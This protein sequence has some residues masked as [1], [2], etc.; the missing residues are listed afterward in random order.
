V[1]TSLTESFSFTVDLALIGGMMLA[2]PFVTYQVWRFVAPGLYSR[3]KRLV[4]PLVLMAV[5]G[6]L[7]G[8]AFGHYLLFP[9]SVE[10]L[11]HWLPPGVKLMAGLSDTFGLYK[12]M[13]LAMI[14][15]FQL[16]TVVLLL[17]RLGAV[18]A[19]LL[20]RN[21]RY[22]ILIIV[23]VA[24]AITQTV[25]AW[26]LFFTSGPMLLMY[27]VSIGVAWL[28]RPRGA[29]A[30]PDRGSSAL[31]LLVGAAI[32]EARRRRRLGMRPLASQ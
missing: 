22:A 32:L 15:V 24:A 11:S 5:A 13:M 31:G 7:A 9:T 6:T 4:V 19:G 28:A 14:A 25:D 29:R 20:W 27:F 10:F 8:G 2:A 30:A 18:T 23:I 3:E 21:L 17:A 12:G 26:N 16:P 1:A